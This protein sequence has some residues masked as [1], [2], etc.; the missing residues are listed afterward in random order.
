MGVNGTSNIQF[1]KDCYVYGNIMSLITSTG[2][3]TA[4]TLTGSYSF[5]KLFY[6]NICL[7]SH[8]TKQLLLPATTLADSCYENMFEGCVNLTSAPVLPA[9]TLADSC[10]ESMFSY[11]TS[12]TTAP[13]LPAE[14]LAKACYYYMFAGCSSLTTAPALPATTLAES[15]YEFMFHA[16]TYLTAAP[17]LPATTLTKECY[18]GMFRYCFKLASVTCLA[19]DISASECTKEWLENAGRDVSGQKTFTTPSSTAWQMDSDNG[20]PYGWTRVD[21]VAP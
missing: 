15:C 19:T 20:I 13:T 10:Y 4:T 3:S 5:C 16:C 2:Y 12:L 14:T 8:A 9:T 21:Y 7:K 1:D 6:Y 18:Y 11:C 17:V